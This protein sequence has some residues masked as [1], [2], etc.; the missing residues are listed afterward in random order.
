MN[1]RFRLHRTFFGLND[2]YIQNVYEEIFLLQYH[3]G[4]SFIEAYNISIQIRRWFLN[5]LVR[6]LKE[7]SEEMNKAS[8]PQG[9]SNFRSSKPK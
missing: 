4:W 2:E 3:M 1:W 7:E 5:R 8:K 6:Q 9:G